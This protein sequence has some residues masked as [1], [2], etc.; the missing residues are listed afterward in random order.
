[1]DFIDNILALA[2]GVNKQIKYIKTE[3]ATKECAR[4]AFHQLARLQASTQRK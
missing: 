1:M 2:A 4:H 3:E